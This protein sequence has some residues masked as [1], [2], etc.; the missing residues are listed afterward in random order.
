MCG[1]E[2]Q[3][4]WRLS[5]LL[6]VGGGH[7]PDKSTAWPIFPQQMLIKEISDFLMGSVRMCIFYGSCTR[8][9]TLSSVFFQ[10]IVF[11]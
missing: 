3:W 4:L 10:K 5:I 8:K 1:E 11:I 6:K 7:T 9:L 2:G